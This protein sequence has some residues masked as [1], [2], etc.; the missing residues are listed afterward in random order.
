MFKNLKQF[1]Q[2]DQNCNVMIQL[3]LLPNSSYYEAFGAPPKVIMYNLSI[4][5]CNKFRQQYCANIESSHDEYINVRNTFT[6][7]TV[8]DMIK[9]MINSKNSQTKIQNVL[10]KMIT[11]KKYALNSIG[12]MLSEDHEN[13]SMLLRYMHDLEKQDNVVL[14]Q[15]NIELT[16]K[17]NYFK[18]K[19]ETMSNDKTSL[20]Y[21]KQMYGE[22]IKTNNIE[23]I[24]FK[25]SSADKTEEITRLKEYAHDLE[26]SIIDL[27]YSEEVRKEQVT[28]I[29]EENVAYKNQIQSLQNDLNASKINNCL[30]I[31][32]K[33]DSI[34]KILFQVKE[35]EA[36]NTILENYNEKLISNMY[37]VTT[38]N[39]D[40][41]YENSRYET[42]V[43]KLTLECQDVYDELFKAD[44][45]RCSLEFEID[46]LSMAHKE[47]NKNTEA[48]CDELR[49]GIRVMRENI[50]NL[51]KDNSRQKSAIVDYVKGLQSYKE[52]IDM[53]GDENIKNH[54]MLVSS[55][56]ENRVLSLQN[57][58]LLLKMDNMKHN[59]LDEYDKLQDAYFS[60][61]KKEDECS[62]KVTICEQKLVA[63]NEINRLQCNETKNANETIRTMKCN[64]KA[65][66]MDLANEE[67]TV[68]ELDNVIKKKN[69]DIETYKNQISYAESAK[70]KLA[71]LVQIKLNKAESV[72]LKLNDADSI[73]EDHEDTITDLQMQL[74]DTDSII[75]EY[76]RAIIDLQT[77]LNNEVDDVHNQYNNIDRAQK[78]TILSIQIKLDNAKNIIEEHKDMIINLRIQSD[79]AEKIIK[80]HENNERC[81]RDRIDEFDNE[82]Q[83]YKL[84]YATCKRELSEY[85]ELAKT[86]RSTMRDNDETNVEYVNKITVE[87]VNKITDQYI[88]FEKLHSI[89]SLCKEENL[90][91]MKQLDECTVNNQKLQTDVASLSDEI[92]SKNTDVQNLRADLKCRDKEIINLS[93]EISS[94]DDEMDDDEIK[95]LK[96]TIKNLESEIE[97]EISE[98]N[99]K[100][101][102]LLQLAQTVTDYKND[103]DE[104][105]ESLRNRINELETNLDYITSLN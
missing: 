72:Q 88:E 77:R 34:K 56:D 89:M 103:K 84:H 79:D 41:E 100:H 1:T 52:M 6:Y 73:I 62:K 12:D 4:S 87:Y 5:D 65:L 92:A 29:E 58:E 57:K 53:V 85:F 31:N 23:E 21:Y 86:L 20:S 7:G 80:E 94:L 8:F 28:T 101:D 19:C 32:S 55:A 82:L 37:D 70:L 45:T 61:E 97:V 81:A 66:E 99:N 44:E 95:L 83:Q 38:E 75:E 42:E 64:Y 40:L 27:E 11:N 90:K 36:Q 33:D 74:S 47:K 98:K 93:N 71:A 96:A 105:I 48:E 17:V 18:Q 49:A 104:L 46:E 76:E 13:F 15:D 78:D 14:T 50:D 35:L 54:E 25:E 3:Q 63:L 43:E 24:M 102:Q 22:K 51:E 67:K 59:T 16:Q 9:Q 91:F 30:M 10:E 69:L 2:N 39:N 68:N 60:Y 26:M